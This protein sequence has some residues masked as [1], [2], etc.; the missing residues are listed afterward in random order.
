MWQTAV[1]GCMLGGVENNADVLHV[2]I[3]LTCPL[4][5]AP[6]LLYEHGPKPT[7]AGCGNEPQ[8]SI[9]AAA[10]KTQVASFTGQWHQKAP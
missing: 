2:D 7:I 3:A 5:P 4:S 9:V 8:D 10:P 1:G 6:C